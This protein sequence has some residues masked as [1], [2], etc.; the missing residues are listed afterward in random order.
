MIVCLTHE[1]V[2]LLRTRLTLQKIVDYTR[3][4]KSYISLFEHGQKMPERD[5]LIS[6][7][8]AAFSLPVTIA[9]RILVFAG[10]APFIIGC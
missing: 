1:R 7:L 9:N 2:R 8:L 6:L 3:L 4:V 5:T 10:F